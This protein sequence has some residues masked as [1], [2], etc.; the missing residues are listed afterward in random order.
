MKGSQPPKSNFYLEKLYFCKQGG[1]PFVRTKDIFECKFL[2]STSEQLTEAG[3][4]R[5]KAKLIP[6]NGLIF[7]GTAGRQGGRLLI[8]QLKTLII[9]PN[10]WVI[11]GGANTICL[12]LIFTFWL[13]KMSQN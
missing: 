9:S 3:F 11:E 5:C 10:L 6:E 8:N 1:I 2:N 13:G 7:V 4:K 12:F